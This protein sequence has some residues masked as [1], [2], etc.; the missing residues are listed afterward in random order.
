[1]KPV[2]PSPEEIAYTLAAKERIKIIPY[3]DQA[4]L[5]LGLT[6]FR[7]SEHK[8]LTDGTPR[9]IKLAGGKRIYFN[10]TSEVK[11]FAYRNETMQLMSS[12][13]RA[14]WEDY[15]EKD[16]EKVR[17]MRKIMHTVSEEDFR[18]DIVLPPAWVGEILTDLWNV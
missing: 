5:T 10:H 2:L 7:L 14:L 12:A 8:Y 11:M 9:V 18:T 16:E 3:G 17:K 15:L 13:V 4:A 6:P 1:M